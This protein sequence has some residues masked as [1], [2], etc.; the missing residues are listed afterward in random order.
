[1][2]LTCGD[3]AFWHDADSPWQG[4]HAIPRMRISR[5]KR[6]PSLPPRPRSMAIGTYRT[7]SSALNLW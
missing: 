3:E 1:V 7:W 5:R 2:P 4:T 6:L